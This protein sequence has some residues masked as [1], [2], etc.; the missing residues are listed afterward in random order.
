MTPTLRFWPLLLEL[1]CYLRNELRQA[2]Q[3]WCV[4]SQMI[5]STG[6]RIKLW[7]LLLGGGGYARPD[8]WNER[9]AFRPYY[10]VSAAFVYC[11]CQYCYF[12][13][14][15]NHN[16]QSFLFEINELQK[17]HPILLS[18]YNMFHLQVRQECP[19]GLIIYT[20]KSKKKLHTSLQTKI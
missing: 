3:I 5:P 19:C 8:L 15:I 4:T 2:V 6:H 7:S 9:D 10:Y 1:P 11:C 17:N 16:F 12:V 14:V 13:C 18:H 20:R